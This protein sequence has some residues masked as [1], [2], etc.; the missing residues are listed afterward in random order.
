MLI[1]KRKKEKKRV[2][3]C[4]HGEMEHVWGV[5]ED[6]HLAYVLQTD[7]VGLTH[8][9]HNCLQFSVIRRGKAGSRPVVIEVSLMPEV[10]SH[11][12]LEG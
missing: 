7:I 1:Q 11:N 8:P 6:V 9:I 4:I 5:R 12:W 10:E 3:R 2:M